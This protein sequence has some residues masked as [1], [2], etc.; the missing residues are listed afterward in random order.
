[1]DVHRQANN[2]PE[3]MVASISSSGSVQHAPRRPKVCRG[4]YKNAALWQVKSDTSINKGKWF[5][6][7]P[8]KNFDYQCRFFHWASDSE[9]DEYFRSLDAE[10]GSEDATLLQRTSYN[11]FPTRTTVDITPN[12][13]TFDNDIGQI[14]ETLAEDSDLASTNS[15][16]HPRDNEESNANEI[17]YDITQESLSSTS[18]AT[19]HSTKRLRTNSDLNANGEYAESALV[20]VQPNDEI[21]LTEDDFDPT[22]LESV[23]AELREE[24]VAKK[25]VSTAENNNN[26]VEDS[27]IQQVETPLT[28]NSDDSE[29]NNIT[30]NENNANTLQDRDSNGSQSSPTAYSDQENV[31]QFTTSQLAEIL[32]NH[33]LAQDQVISDLKS[34]LDFTTKQRDQAAKDLDEAR[35]QVLTV[36]REMKRLRHEIDVSRAENNFL[37]AEKKLLSHDINVLKQ[38]RK[39]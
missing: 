25:S 11:S 15:R 2:V 22:W 38:K 30:A 9:V 37:R 8:V 33:V 27:N 20:L 14:V 29:E 17:S 6:T 35:K 31:P 23:A 24:R 10:Y 12:N 19:E 13:D 7:C 21:I 1:M 3:S 32:R 4:Y 34:K 26:V 5:W 28:V 36:R 39:V 18:S 16:K